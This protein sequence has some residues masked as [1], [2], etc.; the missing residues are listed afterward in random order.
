MFKMPTP[1]KITGRSSSIT[2]SFINSIIPVIQPTSE[3]VEEALAIL[4]MST[5]SC[6]CCYCGASA[7]EWDHL[8]PLVVG[9]KPTGYISEIQN[10][11]PSCGKC[12]Q[13]KG[14]KHWEVWMR[15]DAAL[16]PKVRGVTDI[17]ERIARLKKYEKWGIP[18]FVDF[19]SVVGKELWAIHWSNW[20]LVLSTMRKAQETADQI[21]SIIAKKRERL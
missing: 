6:L 21:K 20:D 14:N 11:V 8:R 17:E 1:V 15:S 16:S 7:S 10:L 13:S 19:E 5:D 3:Q 4:G 12:N 9:Q 2:N 18:T